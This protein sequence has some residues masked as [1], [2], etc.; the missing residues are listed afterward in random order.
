M[1]GRKVEPPVL[2]HCGTYAWVMCCCGNST[3]NF[4]CER[5]GRG[6]FKK[7]VAG[8]IHG[9]AGAVARLPTQSPPLLA[10][11]P[12]LRAGAYGRA[13]AIIRRYADRVLRQAMLAVAASF[14]MWVRGALVPCASSGA[15]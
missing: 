7:P 6:A 10:A 1:L 2:T 12:S 4:E 13:T 5:G 9:C 15:R 11:A 14:G 3:R 8:F